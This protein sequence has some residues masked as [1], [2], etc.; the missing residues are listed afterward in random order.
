MAASYAKFIGNKGEITSF[1]SS[2]CVYLNAAEVQSKKRCVCVWRSVC[3]NQQPEIREEI[4]K[5]MNYLLK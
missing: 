5:Y 3:V 1:L 2:L 4:T